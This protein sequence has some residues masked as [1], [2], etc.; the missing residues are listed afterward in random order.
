MKKTVSLLLVLI[1]MLS[2]C[3][4]GSAKSAASAPS[5]AGYYNASYDGG[6]YAAEEAYA[7]A[8]A[9]GLAMSGAAKSGG[10]EE[11]APEANPEKIIY[12][13]DVRVETTD[14][15]GSIAKVDELLK[16]VGG[17]VESSSVNGANFYN[18]SRGYQSTR[19]ASYTLRIPSARFDE[20]MGSL[21]SL[22]N[23]PYTHTYTE[24]VTSQYYD[25]EAH[26]KT[27]QT[28]EAR[29]LEMMEVAETVE[30]IVILEDRL[31]ELRYRIESL[32]STL[33][34]WDRRVSYSSVSLSI[35]EVR[36]Y[37]PEPE[38]KIS[39]GQRLWH[40]LRDGLLGVA[41]FFEEL[42]V[43]LVGALPTLVILTLL[44]FVLRPVFRKWIARRREKKAAKKERSGQ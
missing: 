9:M 34:N 15:E 23:I 4:C 36:E 42:L 44:F 18:Q 12:S 22:G 7:E 10:T 16:A 30:D 38:M 24:N 31:T 19:S 14:F 8:P 13:S 27:Y 21:S 41:E 1:L 26:L 20:L 40:S 17:W 29:L 3:G 35:E 2:L 37:T 25:T 11:S 43:W 5:E 6:V 39:Y 32:Q 33:K 28:Q